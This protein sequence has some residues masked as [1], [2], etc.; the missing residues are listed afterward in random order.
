M[1]D[2]SDVTAALVQLAQQAIY[3]Q[4]TDAGSVAGV[5]VVIYE[6]W[7]A[8][9]V[10]DK[11]LN[12][13][14][15]HVSVY[16]TASEQLTTRYL[17]HGEKVLGTSTPKITATVVGQTVQLAGAVPADGDPHVVVLKVNGQAYPYEV[18]PSNSLAD[19]AANLAALVA[20]DL[21]GTTAS[22]Q[23]V[24]LPDSARIA[25][26]RVAFT[27]Q[28]ATTLRNQKRVVQITVWAPSPDVRSAVG[29]ALDTALARTKFLQLDDQ[30][31]RL[32]YQSSPVLDSGQKDGLFRRDFL[33]SVD[34]RTTDVQTTT[35]IATETVNVQA[36]G[37]DP[38]L[39]SKGVTTTNV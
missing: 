21:P 23:V 29:K 8:A 13:G 9:Q 12:G 16:P 3:P 7:P 15:A 1:A 20:V 37:Q 26:P 25:T 32:L 10:L 35:T 33:Y 38:S 11:D 39:S 2:I 5:D 22:G 31:A 34:F 19:I 14:F 24:H 27:G 30:A 6:G 4:G 36:F 17:N 18:L 28:Y